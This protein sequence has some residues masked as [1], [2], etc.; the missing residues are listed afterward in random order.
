[1]L[2]LVTYTRRLLSGSTDGLPIQ[3]TGTNTAG[4]NTIHTAVA[5]STDFDEI[6][7]WAN[8][9]GA[10]A[11]TLTIEWGSTSDPA[12]H[13]VKSYSIP[14]YSAPIPI[15]TGQVLNNS[16]VMKAF[17]GTTAV[18]NITGYVNRITA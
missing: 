17:A 9:A 15:A 14:S 10:A 6:Y 2:L 5:G 11:A 12:G 18:I 13:L 7:A 16:K 3:V 8:N 1:M 4:A